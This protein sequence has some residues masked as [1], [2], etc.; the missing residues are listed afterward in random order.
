MRVC[1]AS[2]KRCFIVEVMGRHC[3]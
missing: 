2:H 1:V 3:G